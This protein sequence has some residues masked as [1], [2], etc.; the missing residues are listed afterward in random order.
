MYNLESRI[1]FP[2]NQRTYLEPTSSYNTLFYPNS[3]STSSKI[4]FSSTSET[5]SLK[6]GTALM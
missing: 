6:L 3:G 5:T 1:H 2:E 4:P